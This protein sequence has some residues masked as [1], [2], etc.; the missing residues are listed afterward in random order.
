MQHRPNVLTDKRHNLVNIALPTDSALMGFFCGT[1]CQPAVPAAPLQ[2]EYEKERAM[3]DE[4]MRRI[5]QEEAAEADARRKRQ[6]D[7]QASGRALAL[8]LL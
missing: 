7:M 5:E 1:Q 8:A 3:V 2:E 4:V 6:R